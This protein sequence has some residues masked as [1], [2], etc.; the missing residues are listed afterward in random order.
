M[1]TGTRE[2]YRDWIK[3]HTAYNQIGWDVYIG[4]NGLSIRVY[5]GQLAMI[6]F[7]NGLGYEKN[8]VIPYSDSETI[9]KMYEAIGTFNDSKDLPNFITYSE[10]LNQ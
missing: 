5:H 8:I 3:N 9:D 2:L 10:Y 1:K 4:A 6:E 7:E